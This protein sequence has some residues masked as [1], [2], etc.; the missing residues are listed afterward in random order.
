MTDIKWLMACSALVF[1]MQPGFMCL[2]SGLTRSK[3]SINVAIKNLA[4]LGISV[5]LFWIGGYGWMFG[6]SYL[7]WWGTSEFFTNVDS[8]PEVAAFFL[9]QA[10]FCSTATTI[11]SGAVAERLKF[12]AY[13]I[14]A[15]VVSG[16]I[17]PLFGHWA[18]NGIDQAQ[19][20]GWLGQWGF[21]DFA[22]STVVHSVGAWVSLAALIVIGPRLGRFPEQGRSRKIHGSNLPMSVLGV[23]LLWI[24]WLGFNGG[25]TLVLDD[26]VPSILVHTIMAGVAGLIAAGI[27][28][29][30]LYKRLEVEVL[31]NGAIAGL[32]A[33]T[34]SCH[35]VTTPEA[36]IIGAIG[37]VI[38]LSVRNWLEFWRIDDAVDAVAVHGGAGIWGTLAVALFGQPELLDTGLTPLQQLVVQMVGIGICFVWA[39]GLCWMLFTLIN[40]F[41]PLRVSPEAENMGLNV[42]EHHAKT[43]LYDLFDVMAQQTQKQDLSL[44]VPVEP[45]TEVGHIAQRY[46]QVMDSLEKSVSQLQAQTQELNQAKEK[47]E[48][49]NRAKSTFIANMSHEFRTPLNAIL[50]FTQLLQ[51]SR[52][53]KPD[54]QENLS[55]INRSGEHLLSLINQ[56]LDLSKI[57]AGRIQIHL[58]NFDLYRLLDDLEDMF[59]FKA[60]EKELQLLFERHVSVPRYVRTDAIKLR[61]VLI[62]LLNNAI[63]FT[64]DG[65]VSLRVASQGRTENPVLTFEVEDTGAGIAETE[66]NSLFEA[67]VQTETG[68]AS[69]EGTGL[70]L[71]ISRKFVQLMGGD[72]TVSSQVGKGTLLRFEIMVTPIAASEVEHHQPTAKRQIIALDPACPPYKLL[73]V[74]DKLTN[75]QLL[76]KLLQPLG[77]Q[78][79]TANNG[80]EAIA[81]WESWQPDLIWMD[82]RMPLL[83][84]YGALREI[85][86]QEKEQNRPHTVIIALTASVLEEERT[87]AIPAG[88]DDFM[89]KPFRSDDIFKAITTYL[90]ARFLYDDCPSQGAMSASTSQKSLS[91]EMLA[92]LPPS[93][94]QQLR[95]AILAADLEEIEGIV[96][97]I[98]RELPDLAAVL[99]KY[100]DNFE[101]EKLL[102][103]LSIDNP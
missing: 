82:M 92:V 72:I 39:F 47:A 79:A 51:R 74:D 12:N 25:S 48:A 45:F 15:I 80:Q 63:K 101:Y 103:L 23:M 44:R 10:L 17:Y 84:G 7:G 86:R 66:L 77:F 16:V 11:V 24:G 54:H 34:A 90:G 87:I 31:I 2:E 6:G 38:M 36:V 91:S 59:A 67:F 70:G 95:E 22:G 61:Q 52:D 37:A 94:Q 81:Q 96:G 35:A 20:N 60:E 62:N 26:R 93:Q 89:R 50:G 8:R 69:Q 98:Y 5:G 28:A 29:G 78:L 42:S 14:I 102:T 99:Q 88:F 55:I 43:E 64:E 75:R 33:I 58:S 18:W 76:I 73:I 41:F 85:R 46:N 19:F 13:I 53:L 3:N 49:A 9:F 1:L 30:W 97:I 65:G 4:D 21:V 100:V 57:E 40:R 27:A 83:D 71:P 68:K 32:V 56:V